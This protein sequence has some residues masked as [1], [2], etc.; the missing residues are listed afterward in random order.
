MDQETSTF[1]C[2]I[3]NVR[4]RRGKN[5][6]KPGSHASRCVRSVLGGG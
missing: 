4:E 1:S 2:Q 3:T 6:I 5:E